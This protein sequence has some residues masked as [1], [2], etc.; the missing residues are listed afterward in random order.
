VRSDPQAALGTGRADSWA[1][2]F[3]ARLTANTWP[4]LLIY[5]DNAHTCW[6][7]TV[8]RNDGSSRLRPDAA[9]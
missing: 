4:E 8:S 9:A 2:T 3:P 1:G 5:A 6:Q 7:L